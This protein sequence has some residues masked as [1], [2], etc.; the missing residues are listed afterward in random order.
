MSDKKLVA[1]GIFWNGVQLA[2]NQ[3]FSFIVKLVLAKLLFPEQFGL[4]GM[5]TV[6]T[7][8][9]Q[10]INELG[11]GAALVQRSEKDLRSIHYHTAFW[12][13]L[14]FSVIL[15]LIMCLG[16]GPL[17]ASFYNEPQLISIIPVLSL[18]I[19]FGSVNLVN[20]SQLIRQMNFKRIAMIDSMSRLCSGCLALLL[21][22]LGAGIWS[23]V[24]NSVAP[25]LIAI[26][27][28][29]K[30]TGWLPKLMW[31]KQAF[32]DILGFGVY[33]TGSNML[34]YIYNNIDYLLIGKLLSSA[35]LGVYT[36]AFVLTDTFRSRIMAVVDR[37]VYPFYGKNQHDYA[38]LKKYYL[39]IVQFNC[40]V[41][42]P[43]MI[44]FCVLGGPFL[45]NFFGDKWQDAIAPLQILS[46]AVMF[47]MMV[48]G[49]TA[50]LR[51]LGRPGLE[52]K[53][54]ALKA[55]IY[56]PVLIAGIWFYGVLG[57]AWAVLINKLITLIIA[58]YVFRK[59]INVKISYSELYSSLRPPIAASL[60]AFMAAY[61]AS[62]AGLHFL[63]AGIFLFLSYFL[64]IW[65]FMGAELKLLIKKIIPA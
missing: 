12:T 60:V 8:F 51:G 62:F 42:F 43:V 63:F 57:A 65:A 17:A 1:F 37:A 5:A 59:L 10:V 7:G 58:Q 33:T 41:V 34:S 23:L 40:M 13:G 36:L 54:Q 35:A 2:V 56:I 3:S 21:A 18:G 61:T 29:F 47:N 19:L 27:F 26:P 6:V 38:M 15:F 45:L 64:T 53:L 55:A 50:L 30:A 11:V 39:T 20:R 28:Y 22:F 16:A 24:L 25:V 46:I 14:V 48:S 9:I 32:K 49:N 44:F 31:N 4:V 52:M